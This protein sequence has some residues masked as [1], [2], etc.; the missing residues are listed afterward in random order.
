MTNR[1]GSNLMTSASATASTQ[2]LVAESATI[3]RDH[4][5]LAGTA[6]RM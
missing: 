2:M 5:Y 1:V 6:K 3:Q 4:R